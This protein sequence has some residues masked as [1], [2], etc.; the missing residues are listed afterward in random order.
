MSQVIEGLYYSKDH[1]WA[2]VDGD[3]AYV[4]ITDYA[5]TSLGDIVYCDAEPVGAVVTAGGTLGAVESVKAA[6]DILSPV[7]GAVTEVNSDLLDNPERL[8]EDAYENWIVKITL[9]DASE[10]NALMDAADYEAY[11]ESL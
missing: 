10:L 4:G 3:S 7:S 1:E 6:S 9:N 5:R 8:A 11:C 2:R